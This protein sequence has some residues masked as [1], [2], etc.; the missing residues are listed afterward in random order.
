LIRDGA[1]V[2]HSIMAKDGLRDFRGPARRWIEPVTAARAYTRAHPG[3]CFEVR[4]EDLVREPDAVLKRVADFLGLPCDLEASRRLDVVAEMGDVGRFA[5]HA[6]VRKPVFGDSIGAGR[7]DLS[8]EQ[9]VQLQALI[10]PLL[11]ELGYARLA[12]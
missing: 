8:P 10:G 2:V 12:P 9:A 4:Y 7:R 1:D 6:S 5:H 11:Q 3:Q